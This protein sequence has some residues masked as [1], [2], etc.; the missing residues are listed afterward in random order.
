M[1]FVLYKRLLVRS[2]VAY[3][4]NSCT[5]YVNAQYLPVK[6]MFGGEELVRRPACSLVEYCCTAKSQILYD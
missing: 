4:R 3:Y 2:D 6:L 1:F 5:I